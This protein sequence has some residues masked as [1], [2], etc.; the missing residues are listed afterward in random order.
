MEDGPWQRD[1]YCIK[2]RLTITFSLH[3]RPLMECSSLPKQA[4]ITGDTCAFKAQPAYV[5]D[6]YL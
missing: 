5:K 3:M 6:I 4:K 2:S 1:F